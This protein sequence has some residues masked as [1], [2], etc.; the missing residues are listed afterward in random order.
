MMVTVK[1]YIFTEFSQFNKKIQKRYMNQIKY[2]QCQSAKESIKCIQS[3][4]TSLSCP[5]QPPLPPGLSISPLNSRCRNRGA[6]V[7]L[8]P[9]TPSPGE[10]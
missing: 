6:S 9:A 3:S 7:A 2:N 10:L 5:P 4:P 8:L 1:C